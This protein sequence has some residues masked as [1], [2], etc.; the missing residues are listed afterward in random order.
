MERDRIGSERA[1]AG[2]TVGV[3]HSDHWGASKAEHVQY[4]SSEQQIPT[5]KKQ[6]PLG[7]ALLCTVPQHRSIRNVDPQA[8]F[9]RAASAA[10]APPLLSSDSLCLAGAVVRSSV[11]SASRIANVANVACDGPSGAALLQSI[12]S[13][14]FNPTFPGTRH[15]IG[16]GLRAPCGH[17]M[18]TAKLIG[19]CRD[20][21]V[22][23]PSLIHA[24]GQ[25]RHSSHL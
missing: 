4:A 17:W 19:F 6:P 1:C 7:S 3:E 24:Q 22:D 15:S 5:D 16:P 11:L 23:A 21:L 9:L 12:D 20:C 14:T 25:S 8:L 13:S 10:A 18:S 2:A